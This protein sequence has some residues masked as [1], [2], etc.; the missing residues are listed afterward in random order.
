MVNGNSEL[1]VWLLSGSPWTAY[2]TRLDLLSEPQDSEM[3]VRDRVRMLE[4]PLIV[5]LINELQAWPGQVLNSHKSAGQHFHK[6]AFLAELGV[7][8]NDPGM[9]SILEKVM[10]HQSEEGPFS[11]PTNVPIHFG[12]SGKDEFAWALCDA[13]LQVYSLAKMG[14]GQDS[15]IIRA[16][17][18][19]LELGRENGY[20]CKVSKELGKFRGPGRKEDPC[21]YATLLMLKVMAL[22]PSDIVSEHAR[23]SVESLLNLWAESRDRHPYMFFMGTDFRKLKA[24]LIWYDIVNGADTLSL[25]PQVKGDQR[26]KEM[27]NLIE[28][29]ADPEGRFTPESEWKAWKDWDFGQKK[30]PSAWLTY[31]VYRI[32]PR[33]NK[34]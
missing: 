8:R 34:P 20:P 18:Y 19:L 28:S 23:N 13:P 2:R 32:K 21:P 22:Y 7:N 30:Q 12:G 31:L 3:V 14:F 16:K 33:L 5:A 11:L 4:H 15:R 25:F 6:L 29:K 24:P 17:D 9:S 26:F 27:L 10:E 1:T